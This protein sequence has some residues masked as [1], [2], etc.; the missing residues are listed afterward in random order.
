MYVLGR[1]MAQAV[2]GRFLT[3]DSTRGRTLWDVW[4]IKWH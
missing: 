1:A 4:W 3:L 2:S